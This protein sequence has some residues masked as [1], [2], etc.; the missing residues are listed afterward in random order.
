M[1]RS[2]PSSDGHRPN[3][4][5]AGA[6]SLFYAISLV[7][8]LIELPEA[9]EFLFSSWWYAAVQN[10]VGINFGDVGNLAETRGLLWRSVFMLM[11]KIQLVWVLIT[12]SRVGPGLI[13]DDIKSRA[14]PI[15]FARPIVPVTYLLGKWL[16]VAAYIGVVMLVPNLLSLMLGVLVTGGLQTVGET[17]RLGFDLIVSGVGV[18]VVG[19]ALILA[20]S[21]MT[22]DKR[23]ASVAWYALCLLPL[24]AQQI[25]RENLPAA[26]TTGFLGS[27]SLNGNVM[28]LTERLF[29]MRNAFEASGLSSKVFEKIL[30]SPV[31][32]VYPAIILGTVT[33]AA[34]GLC[35]WRVVRFSRCAASM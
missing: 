8:M 11:I 18:M 35:Y 17:A 2:R 26:S 34:V 10:V 23:Y 3:L 30:L 33:V 27:V 1:A 13:A 7:E 29:D 20:L 21:S 5:V 16:V 32:A 31:G 25:I 9:Q 15:Y 4:Q 19:G 28:V 24:I 14:L 22:T 12:V 6:A